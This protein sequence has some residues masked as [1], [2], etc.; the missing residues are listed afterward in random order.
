[1]RVLRKPCELNVLAEFKKFDIHKLQRGIVN[2]E[3]L[4]KVLRAELLSEEDLESR[5]TEIMI[6]DS[7]GDG[8]LTFK[9]FYDNMLRKVPQEWLNWISANLKKG[10]R[11]DFIRMSLEMNGVE[12]QLAMSLIEKT[13]EVGPLSIGK[14]FAD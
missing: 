12:S 5:V 8:L 6:F 3:C 11:E 9:D 4:R 13:K 7:D 2:R 14:T 10:V 1:M